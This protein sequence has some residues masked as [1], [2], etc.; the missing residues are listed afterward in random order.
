MFTL[1]DLTFIRHL[2]DQTGGAFSPTM[3]IILD[4]DGSFPLRTVLFN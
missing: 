2:S 3:T 1:T 4:W